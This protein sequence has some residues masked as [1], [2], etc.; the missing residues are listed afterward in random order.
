MLA[1]QVPWIHVPVKMRQYF[2]AEKMQL[3]AIA[4]P[5]IASH[6]TWGRFNDPVSLGINLVLLPG[7]LGAL[8]SGSVQHPQPDF[9]DGCLGLRGGLMP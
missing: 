2:T 1:T 9:L 3:P 4:L 6:R 7:R 8:D 5:L